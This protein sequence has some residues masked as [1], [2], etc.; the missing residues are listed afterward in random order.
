MRHEGAVD[1][2]EEMNSR[3]DV[4]EV[5]VECV[6]VGGAAQGEDLIAV[7]ASSAAVATISICTLPYAASPA[8]ASSLAG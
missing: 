1:T 7:D 2:P 4:L 8:S 6:L 5:A 3:P